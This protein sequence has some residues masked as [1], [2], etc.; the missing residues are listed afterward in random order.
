MLP[1]EVRVTS[2][3]HPLFG[4]LVKAASFKRLQGVMHLV[5]ELPD[6]SPGTIRAAATDVLGAGEGREPAVVLDADGLRHLRGLVMRMIV[7]GE[8]GVR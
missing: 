3:T 5:I 4:R 6:G 2:E 8:R 1:C 7:P